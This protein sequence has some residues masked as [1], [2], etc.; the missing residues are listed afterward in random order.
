MLPCNVF[1]CIA[2]H[3]RFYVVRCFLVVKAWKIPVASFTRDLVV[4]LR[5]LDVDCRMCG[6]GGAGGDDGVAG[7]VVRCWFGSGLVVVSWCFHPRDENALSITWGNRTLCHSCTVWNELK[8][9]IN[10]G[11]AGPMLRQCWAALGNLNAILCQYIQYGH[12][13]HAICET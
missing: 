10:S 12:I 1:S 11:A 9:K 13:F 5:Q 7:L 6:V 8:T 2:A 4:G 3:A